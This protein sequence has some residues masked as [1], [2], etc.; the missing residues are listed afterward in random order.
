MCPKIRVR[1]ANNTNNKRSTTVGVLSVSI[2]CSLVAVVLSTVHAVVRPWRNYQTVASRRRW[3]NE[4]R[5]LSYADNVISA[6]IAVIRC[7]LSIT[8][9]ITTLLLL[10]PLQLRSITAAYYR[11]CD[12]CDARGAPVGSRLAWDKTTTG[13]SVRGPDGLADVIA[14][15]CKT[16]V[17]N[18]RPYRWRLDSGNS[19]IAYSSLRT[20]ENMCT[21]LRR[22]GICY[23][24]Q[25]WQWVIFCDPWPVWPT[26]HDPS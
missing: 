6:L 19:E 1:A 12:A 8:L 9:T 20:S 11:V 14:A 2:C 23:R 3:G 7:R 13:A 22:N 18:S 17:T 16:S 5:S 24:N 10:L 21:Y 4:E 15:G 26:T 25:S